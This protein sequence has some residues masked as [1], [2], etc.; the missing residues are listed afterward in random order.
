MS[1][2][3]C[4]GEACTLLGRILDR[5]FFPRQ[6]ELCLWVSF[7]RHP[8]RD[9]LRMIWTD[10]RQCKTNSVHERHFSSSSILGIQIAQQKLILLYFMPQSRYYLHTWI[11]RVTVPFMN[12]W[13]FEKNSVK[14]STKPSVPQVRSMFWTRSTISIVSVQVLF[15][16]KPPLQS[17]QVTLTGQKQKR[18]GQL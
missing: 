17:F 16:H 13:V 18:Q 15:H 4:E 12:S 9:S 5:V 8:L 10:R 3:R 11:R 14:C 1:R 6:L 2:L 7:Q